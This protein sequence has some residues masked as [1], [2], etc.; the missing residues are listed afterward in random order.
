[1]P[2]T[3]SSNLV[4]KNFGNIGGTRTIDFANTSGT[5]TLSGSVTLEKAATV[6][7]A[8]GGIGNISGA[9]TG[10]HL[11]TKSGGGTLRFNNSVAGPVTVTEG[12]LGGNTTI[13]GLTTLNSG[14]TLAPGNSIGTMTFSNGLALNSGSDVTME[15][16]TTSSS[17]DQINITGGALAYAGRLVLNT[18]STF[19]S[20]PNFTYTLFDGS[21]ALGS[22][23]GNWTSVEATGSYAGTFNTTDYNIWTR[24]TGDGTLWTYTESLG[25]LTVIPEPSTWALIGVGSA[26]V[27]WRLRRRRDG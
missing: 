15:L 8:A 13:G 22:S 7:V 24:N 4:V 19:G 18:G 20:N 5:A 14:A 10:S 16:S 11:I 26:F 9:V 6:S 25:T 1:L 17:S 2:N 21:G 12:T 27:L 23:T 3:Y